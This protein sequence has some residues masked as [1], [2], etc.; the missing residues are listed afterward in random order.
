LG[1]LLALLDFIYFYGFD[2]ELAPLAQVRGRF[3]AVGTAKALQALQLAVFA[4]GR[5][6][7]DYGKNVD[8]EL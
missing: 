6:M 7:G 8:D 1:R 4:A 5:A 2:L 3:A